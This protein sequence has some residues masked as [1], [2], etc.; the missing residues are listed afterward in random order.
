LVIR[1]A[2]PV[3]AA[4]IV[5]VMEVIASERGHSAI[6]RART[7]AQETQMTKC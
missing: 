4:G 2:S 5:A 3:D 1:N 7:V 6:D